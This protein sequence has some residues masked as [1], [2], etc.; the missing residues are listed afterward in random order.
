[1]LTELTGRNFKSLVDVTV[2]FLRRAVLFGPNAAGKEQSPRRHRRAVGNSQRAD[3]IG[4]ARPA[5]G[6][7][8]PRVRGVLGPGRRLA[9]SAE[10]AEPPALPRGEPRCGH[11]A[12]PVPRRADHR[13][14]LRPPELR[15]RVSR[16]VGTNRQSERH[17]G[18]RARRLEAA[19]G[20]QG[21]AGPS[22][23]GAGRPLFVDREFASELVAAMN[24][25]RRGRCDSSL[26]TFI[27]GFR[28]RIRESRASAER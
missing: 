3:A 4:R 5:A 9:D 2:E 20:P 21:Q 7:K 6:G 27:G 15:R 12:L 19:R 22:A 25:Y 23:R 13:V 1:M 17:A 10:A 18:D 8:G 26:R 28:G 16:T 14:A 24:L 11:R